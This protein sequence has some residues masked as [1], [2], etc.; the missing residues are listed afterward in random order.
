MEELEKGEK[1]GITMYGR[2]YCRESFM[3]YQNILS[4]DSELMSLAFFV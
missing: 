4:D 3:W 2:F 1:T